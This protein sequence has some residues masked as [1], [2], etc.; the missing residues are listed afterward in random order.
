MADPLVGYSDVEL[1]LTAWYRA[2]IAARPED[3]CQGVEV[4]NAEPVGTTFPK[5]LVVI[6]DDGGPD[7]SIATAETAVRVSV[8]AGTRAN[9][10]DAV[11]LARIVH[12]LR[13]QIPAPGFAVTLGGTPYR[14]PVAAVIDSNRP[15]AVTEEQDR[16]RRLI[17]MTLVVS[18]EPL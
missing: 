4:D 11:D 5:R 12:G 17:T 18:P 10:K 6:N 1:F 16:A 8:L 9:P 7:T 3:C 15:I 13:T 14:N 2:A